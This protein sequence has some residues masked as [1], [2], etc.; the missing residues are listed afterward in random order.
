MQ[1]IRDP[2]DELTLS[3]HQKG[4]AVSKSSTNEFNSPIRDMNIT[5]EEALKKV[6]EKK[7]KIEADKK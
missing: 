1:E 4:F 2:K 3:G 6:V 5:K 7:N